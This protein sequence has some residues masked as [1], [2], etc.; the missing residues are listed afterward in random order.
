MVQEGTAAY[1]PPISRN[2]K[3]LP[4]SALIYWKRPEE[5]ANLIFDWVSFAL[6]YISL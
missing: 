6:L 1:D 3:V 4:T 2:N 5:W